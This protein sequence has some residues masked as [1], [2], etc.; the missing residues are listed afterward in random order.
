MTLKKYKKA[1]LI[2]PLVSSAISFSMFF[3]NDYNTRL[4]SKVTRTKSNTN[5]DDGNKLTL[6][7]I[8]LNLKLLIR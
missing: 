6:N 5:S 7:Q 3:M 4:V 2:L 8:K 1:F